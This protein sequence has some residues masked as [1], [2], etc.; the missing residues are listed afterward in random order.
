MAPCPKHPRCI[1]LNPHERCAGPVWGEPMSWKATCPN[2]LHVK[3]H[4]AET[5]EICG[6]SYLRPAEPVEH[7]NEE[8]RGA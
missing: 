5:C 3:F 4:D 2:C 7:C 6:R 1:I 8:R